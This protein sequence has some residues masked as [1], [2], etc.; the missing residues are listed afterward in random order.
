LKTLFLISILVLSVSMVSC[1]NE[2]GSQSS[3]P[4][5]SN[6]S[7]NSKTGLAFPNSTNTAQTNLN[8]EH[9]KLGHRCDIAVGAPLT[10]PANNTT[11]QANTF[12]NIPANNEAVKPSTTTTAIPTTVAPGMN[13]QHGQPGHRCDIAVGAPL[14]SPVK[15]NTSTTPNASTNSSAIKNAAVT[16]TAPGMNPQHGQPGHRCDIAVGSPLADTAKNKTSQASTSQTTANAQ[17]TNTSA[18]NA[19]TNFVEKP[20]ENT[21]TTVVPGMNPKHGE[22]GHRCDIAVG[23]PLNS[24]PKQ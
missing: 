7:I 16:T 17:I 4:S 9:G 13:P 19:T 24:K 18:T 8:P 21:V 3:S 10:D 12:P 5:I 20:A 2:A 23:A 15:N 14:N 1:N 6:S 11:A 22:P